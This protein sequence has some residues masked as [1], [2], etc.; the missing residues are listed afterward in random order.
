MLQLWWVCPCLLTLHSASGLQLLK[1][2]E[3]RGAHE[4]LDGFHRGL[5]SYVHVCVC[6]CVCLSADTLRALISRTHAPLPADCMC[7]RIHH[8]CC[9]QRPTMTF[10]SKSRRRPNFPKSWMPTATNRA[11][12]ASHSASSLMDK[13]LLT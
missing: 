7:T 5:K 8:G 2:G 12:I 13:E 6:V 3:P 1:R 10:S 9:L 11:S 4:I